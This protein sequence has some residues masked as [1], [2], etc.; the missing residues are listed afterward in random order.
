LVSCTAL[1]L[2]AV[3]CGTAPRAAAARGTALAAFA[4]VY[5][6]LQHP[7]CKNCHPAGRMPLQ[8]DQSL[9][10][11]QNVQGGADGLGRFA[12]RC[13]N[14]HR[15]QNLPGVAQPPGAPGWHLPAANMPLVF[16]GRSPAAL[17][18]QL[19]APEHNGQRSH[20]QILEHIQHDPLVLWAWQPGDGRTPVPLPH[21]SF[22]TAVHTWLAGGA[23]VPE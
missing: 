11:G 8:G 2:V 15:D 12:L 20:A 23:P 22:V 3:Q 18:R 14:C 6:V 16:E 21:A 19:V 10:H 5:E 9:P 4:T 1:G 17:A 13:S 7:R